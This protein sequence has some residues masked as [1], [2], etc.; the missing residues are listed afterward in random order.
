LAGAIIDLMT[1]G[2]KLV[3]Q[4]PDGPPRGGGIV[5]MDAAADERSRM[6]APR[7]DDLA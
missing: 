7:D 5:E 1:C 3:S 2:R 4:R 6:A